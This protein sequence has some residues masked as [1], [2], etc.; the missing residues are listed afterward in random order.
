MTS[1]SYANK[2]RKNAK[3]KIKTTNATKSVSS[4]IKSVDKTKEIAQI[5]SN[6]NKNRKKKHKTPKVTTQKLQSILERKESCREPSENA[7]NNV[8]YEEYT[9]A[10]DPVLFPNDSSIE[11][12]ALDTIK[13]VLS[14]LD[15]DFRLSSQFMSYHDAIITFPDKYIQVRNECESCLI[16]P[17]WNR[18]HKQLSYDKYIHT[19]RR[20]DGHWI[21]SCDKF[22]YINSRKYCDHTIL[23]IVYIHGNPTKLPSLPFKVIIIAILKYIQVSAKYM[24]LKS[25]VSFVKTSLEIE[26]RKAIIKQTDDSDVESDNECENKSDDQ[27]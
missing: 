27:F 15:L 7:S 20:D 21:C 5:K 17:D 22:K 11:M 1:R 6:Q 25:F 9:I 2:R 12:S 24:N 14:N 26:S 23:S 19:E 8:F 18:K 16:L 10:S 3:S 4:G 13:N